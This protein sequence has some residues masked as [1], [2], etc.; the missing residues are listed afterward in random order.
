M[1]KAI[2]FRALE[3]KSNKAQNVSQDFEQPEMVTLKIVD[4]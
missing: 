4:G 2:S 3:K 1:A